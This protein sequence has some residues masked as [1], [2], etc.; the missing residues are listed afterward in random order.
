[1]FFLITCRILDADKKTNNFMDIKDILHSDQL[2]IGDNM[3]VFNEVYERISGLV[4]ERVHMEI[5][6]FNLTTDDAETIDIIA[7]KHADRYYDEILEM[8]NLVL[9]KWEKPQH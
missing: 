3:D 2:S 4:E 1:M 9:N 6:A 5:K 7:K 8:I